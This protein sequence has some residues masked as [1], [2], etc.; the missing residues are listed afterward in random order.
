MVRRRELFLG[1]GFLDAYRMAEKRNKT[2]RD[3]C[4][5][6]VSPSLYAFVSWSE[7]W[8]RLLCFF[9]DHCFLH[10]MLLTDPDLGEFDEDRILRCL[11]DAG[12]NQDKLKATKRFLEGLEDYDDDLREGSRLRQLTGWKRE[13][14]RTE[15]LSMIELDDPM[16]FDDWPSIWSELARIRGATYVAQESKS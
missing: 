5:I 1:R 7:H 3:V 10:P 15:P 4:G 9:E 11:S 16:A 14:E 13:K 6:L 8:C 12:A 2:V